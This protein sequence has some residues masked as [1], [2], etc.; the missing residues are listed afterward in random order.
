MSTTSIDKEIVSIHNIF[1]P[2]L[3]EIGDKV[4]GTSQEMYDR[5]IIN[6]SGKLQVLPSNVR[7]EGKYSQI[8][9]AIRRSKRKMVQC[10]LDEKILVPEGDLSPG[11]HQVQ[12]LFINSVGIE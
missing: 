3:H 10:P 8:I 11:E 5:I 4:T 9:A 1:D 12:V 2:S 7:S 6:R